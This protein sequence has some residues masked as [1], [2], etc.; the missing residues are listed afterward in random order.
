VPLAHFSGSPT[1]LFTYDVAAPPARPRF[2]V[3]NPATGAPDAPCNVTTRALP[4][5][6]EDAAGAVAPDAVLW[7][8]GYA[9][10]SAAPAAEGVAPRVYIEADNQFVVSLH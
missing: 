1:R 8:G 7:A 3:T 9:F 4:T 10:S 2:T 6:D 5:A